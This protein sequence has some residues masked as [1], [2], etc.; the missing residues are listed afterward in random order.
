VTYKRIAVLCATVLLCL[1]A[2][3]LLA[4]TDKSAL[5][6]TVSDASGAVVPGV[7]ISLT[8]TE[9][10]VLVRS[11]T[12]D[13]NGNFEFP[14]LKP[15]RYRLEADRA[16]FKTYI[17]EDLRIESQQTRRMDVPLQVGSTAESITVEAG[18]ALI[19]TESG[20]ISG[21]VDKRQFADT[22]LIDVYPSPMAVLTTVPGIQGA[23]WEL[24][25]SGQNRT[26]LSQGMDGI[27]NDRTGEQTNNMSFFEEVTVVTVNNSAESSRVSNYNMVSK[28]GS[29]DWHGMAYYKHF[30]SA[31]N[32]RLFFDVRKTPFIQHEWQGE[33]GGPVWKDKTYVYGSWFAQKI[34]LGFFKRATVPTT[35]MRQGDFSQL[36]RNI[37]D[38]VTGQPFPGN[39]IPAERLNAVSAKTQQLYYPAP[40]IGGPNDLT[41]NFGFTHPFHYDFYK[42]NWPFLRVD[43]NLTDK[44]TVYARWTQRK[45][46]YVL[47]SGLPDFIWTR[48]RDHRQLVV[49]DT[50]IFSPV[51]VNTFR[52][53]QNR[54][55]IVDGLETA[56][57]TPLQGD[58]AVA[59]IGLQGVNGGGY[60]AQGFPRMNISGFTTLNTTAGG[61][62]NDDSDYAFEDSL[63]WSSGKHVW[64][65]GGEYKTYT[66]FTGVIPEGTFGTFTFNGSFTGNA[67]ADFLLGLPRTSVR[68]DP[69]TNRT[70]T[71]KEFGI[72]VTD[73]FKV[74][75]KLTLDYGVRWDYYALPTYTD[76]LMFNWDKQ[77]GN[78]VVTEEARS[79]ISPLYPKTINIT[80]GKVVPDPDMKNIRP[81][82]SAAYR[83]KDTFVI[84]GGYGA[85]SER[86]DYFTRVAS[87][88]PFQISETYTNDIVDG[89]PLFAFP[90]PFPSSLASA[91]IPSQSITRFPLETDN[92]TIHQYNI[93]IERELG[94]IGLRASYIGSRSIGLNYSLNINKPQPSTIPFAQ[95][96]RP[97]S[98]FVNITEHRNDG[99]LHYDSLQVQA[100]KRVGSFTFNAHYTWSKTLAN[101]LNTE[102]PYNVT[103]NWANT[104][105]D[106]NHYAVINTMWQMPFGKG[107]RFMSSAPAV[108]DRV[109]GGWTV[110]TVSYF[111]S[112][113]H[114]SPAFSGSDPSNTNSFG[115]LPDRIGDG[116]LSDPNVDRWF[117]PS[118]FRVPVAGRFGNSGV[119][120]LTGQGLNVHHLSVAKR[121][122]IT[123]RVSTTLTSS[124]SNLFNTPHFDTQSGLVKDISVANTGKYTAVVPDFN[125]EKQTSRHIM[126]K[127]RVEF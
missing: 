45:T 39:R 11:V 124:A 79:R 78:V 53:G 90:S 55:Y 52:F 83:L 84:R 85:F 23:G 59:A 65:F 50:H 103:S 35:L 80:T 26:Q 87:G 64:K 125:P 40:N 123:E 110:Q 43:H 71:N 77:T 56:G 27:E 118:A 105:L 100:H 58:K 95:S 54:N 76:G 51:V 63:T 15:G 41:N 104:E 32:A 19:T 98:Q 89:Q 47:D 70:A 114:F 109:L 1:H 5:R 108:V 119:N 75:N 113:L 4:Q 126:L 48:L 115:G 25:V 72:F 16:G 17:A 57:V 33:L 37:T 31:L 112:G 38:P 13:D 9:T 18:A 120:I 60:S 101:Y 73:T 88:G 82:V 107:K 67:Y 36:G 127:L 49:S 34:P 30:N 29:S 46:P 74:S 99:G 12:T 14:D 24:R 94:N 121:F 96:R 97:W 22:P 61:V 91:A 81:R 44:N 86:I 20:A 2:G 7:K 3:V 102:N 6:G 62:R 28:R 69:F 68:L 116:I 21:T 106:R 122:R 111:A 93:S 8:E 66:Q 42:G 117:D 92:G 10:G